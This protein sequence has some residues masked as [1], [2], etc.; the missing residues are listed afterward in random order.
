M[1]IISSTENQIYKKVFRL[2]A[3]KYRDKTGLYIIEGPNLIGEALNQAET[4]KTVIFK[5]SLILENVNNEKNELKNKL[6][7]KGIEIYAINDKIF[8]NLSDTQTTQGVLG[9]VKKPLYDEKKFFLSRIK[10]NGNI[11]VLDRLQDPGNIGTII[12]TADGA[13]YQGALILKGTADIF[14]PKIVRAAAG[15]IFR[16]PMLIIDSPEQAINLL[17]NN[18]KK[19]IC[20]ALK[21]AK[22]Y[23]ECDM[24]RNVAVIIGNEGNGVCEEFIKNSDINVKIPMKSTI[25]SLNAAVAAGILIYESVRK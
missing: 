19:V 2:G 14:S 25:E 5:K 15:S 22:N 4:L 6:E 1:K 17:K 24:S 9:I 21:D 13:G 10:S 23:Y 3:K 12:R 7:N 18:N 20:T 8:D 11:I 16:L